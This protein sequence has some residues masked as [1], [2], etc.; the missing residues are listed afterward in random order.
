MY[1]ILQW[2]CRGLL[3]KYAEIG[4][5]VKRFHVV[6][7]QETWLNFNNRISFK[8]FLVFRNDRP[9]PRNGG[10]SLILC[11]KNLNPVRLNTE[12]LVFPGCDLTALSFSMN[13]IRSDKLVIVSFYKPPDIK[14]NYRQWRCLFEGISNLA[15]SSQ[16]VVMG[17]FNA[18][19]ETWGSTKS[20]Q[21]GEALNRY[22]MESSFRYLNNG[23]ATRISASPNYN[24]VPDLTITNS[25]G[26]NFVWQVGEDPLWEVTIS[27]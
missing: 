11:K 27:Q 6:C 5:L 21:S 24:S 23:T 3:S 18:Q 14:F 17:D 19:S 7:L 20:N 8:D 9:I 4:N 10:G 13:D 22:L 25:L 12:G 16:I 15:P 2:N 26:L 1:N